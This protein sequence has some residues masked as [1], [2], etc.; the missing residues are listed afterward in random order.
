VP[1]RQT[2]LQAWLG[3]YPVPLYPAV[4]EQGPQEKGMAANPP[5]A[6]GTHAMG[7]YFDCLC[8]L[9]HVQVYTLGFFE[10]FEASVDGTSMGPK[11][12]AGPFR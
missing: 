10:P 8:G 11:R 6:N 2:H 1:D 5:H 7:R 9:L 12:A 3:Y 4:E